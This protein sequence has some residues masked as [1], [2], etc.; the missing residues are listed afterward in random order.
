MLTNHR[1]L[2]INIHTNIISNIS[3][4]LREVLCMSKLPVH[5]ALHNYYLKLTVSNLTTS[6]Y[7]NIA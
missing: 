6:T 3:I 7:L 5:K 2:Q 1:F 4:K